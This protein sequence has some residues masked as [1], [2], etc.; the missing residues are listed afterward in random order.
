[1]IRTVAWSVLYWFAAALVLVGLIFMFGDCDT[2]IGE[3]QQCADG[4]RQ[5]FWTA[6]LLAFA[7]YAFLLWRRHRNRPRR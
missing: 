4:Q 6:V 2:A 3:V 1:M 7:F 5:I